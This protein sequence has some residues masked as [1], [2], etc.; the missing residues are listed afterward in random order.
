MGDHPTGGLALAGIILA[1]YVR[2][3]TGMGQKVDVSLL[4]TGCWVNGVDLQWALAFGSDPP[5][6][7][8][9]QAINPLSNSYQARC[10]RWLRFCMMESDR[11]WPDLCQALAGQTCGTTPVWIAFPEGGQSRG[12]HRAPRGDHRHQGPRR[13]GVTFR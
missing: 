8:R 7:S 1:L 11:Y 3:R 2:E 6:F 12:S 10:G 4:G 9:K 13:M 5:R